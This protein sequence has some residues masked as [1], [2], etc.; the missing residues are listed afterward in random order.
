V[1]VI[2]LVRVSADKRSIE[3]KPQPEVAARFTARVAP[4][5]DTLLAMAKEMAQLEAT[6]HF[7]ADN[8]ASIVEWAT[9]RGLGTGLAFTLVRVGRAIHKFPQFEE[10]VRQG[11]IGLEGLALACPALMRPGSSVDPE[12]WR[13]AIAT[14]SRTELKRKVQ[15]TLA[16]AE[17]GTA[18]LVEISVVVKESTNEDWKRC[19]VL[20]SRK[21][22]KSLDENQTFERVVVSYLD[23]NDPLRVKPGTRRMPDTGSPNTG[24][25]NTGS[26]STGSPN[27][28]SPSTGSPNP[29]PPTANL[30]TGAAPTSCAVPSSSKGNFHAEDRPLDPPATSPTPP[31]AVRDRG[32]PYTACG[33]P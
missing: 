25:P 11:A 29:N 2:C 8:C 7:I 28:G 31:D 17:L 5:T 6:A 3:W 21:E 33:G 10:W 14:L 1:I 30:P 12:V 16:E 4:L 22:G 9:N 15:R 23:V 26:P 13:V 32:L 19:R 27:T 24:S 18:G 20:A